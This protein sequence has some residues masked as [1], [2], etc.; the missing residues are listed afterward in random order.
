MRAREAWRMRGVAGLAGR[1]FFSRHARPAAL[2]FVVIVAVA[3]LGPLA[4]ESA[5]EQDL[6]LRN[7]G[8]SSGHWLGNDSFGRDVFARILVAASVTM[9]ASL[10][11]LAIALV[12]GVVPGLVSGYL[13]GAVDAVMNRIGDAMLSLPPLVLALAII[14]MAGPGLTEAMVAVGVV[15]APRFFRL[16]RGLAADIAQEPYVEAARADGLG[17][18]RIVMHHIVPGV[19]GSLLVQ[20]SFIFGFIIAAE[21]GLSF[22]GLGVQPPTPSWGSMLREAYSQVNQSWFQVVPPAVAITLAVWA[23][24]AVGDSLHEVLG[25]A[26]DRA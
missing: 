16:S 23:L 4:T 3:V 11:A 10:L 19:L 17:P 9:R 2:V 8:P 21:A 18:S 25:G 1:V 13:G 22:L 26:G 12:L 15:L 14:G 7:R 6:L 20:A 24:A 5:N